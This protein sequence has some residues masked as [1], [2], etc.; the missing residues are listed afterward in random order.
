MISRTQRGARALSVAAHDVLIRAYPASFR[1]EYANEMRWAFSRLC[2]DAIASRGLAG[3]LEVWIDTLVDFPASAVATH[4]ERWQ[5]RAPL[6]W[7][8]PL[9]LTVLPVAVVARTMIDGADVAASFLHLSSVAAYCGATRLWLVMRG[10]TS[11]GQRIVFVIACAAAGATFLRD[12]RMCMDA[13]RQ[14]PASIAI[15]FA[16]IAVPVAAVL[17]S[18]RAAH[19]YLEV[20]KPIT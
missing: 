17:A 10:A 15:G 13:L 11:G 5:E 7:A 2:A 1:A 14:S 16:T 18:L 4:R 19:A 8:T 12:A 6:S 3:L 9:M 20:R